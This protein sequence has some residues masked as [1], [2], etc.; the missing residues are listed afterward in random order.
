MAR[1]HGLDFVELSTEDSVV[2]FEPPVREQA[3][4]VDDIEDVVLDVESVWCRKLT[5][6]SNSRVYSLE[7]PA[8][9][10]EL[11]VKDQA[12]GPEGFHL[13]RQ[14]GEETLLPEDFVSTL[15]IPVL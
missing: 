7:F 5:L 4:G 2:N 11:A 13:V 9:H 10:I 3:F 14:V 1:G 15:P 8:V 12:G 6:Y